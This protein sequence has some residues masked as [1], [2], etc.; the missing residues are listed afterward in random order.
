MPPTLNQLFLMVTDLDRSVR[1]YRDV[2]DLSVVEERDSQAVFDTG[3]CSLV[4]EEDFDAETLAGFNLDPPGDDRGDGAIV[5][6]EV[7]DVEAAYE[8]AADADVGETLTEPRRVDWGRELFLV[9]DPD[10]YVVEVS[11]PVSE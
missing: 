4:V 2:L 10:G 8:T 6:L 1:F 11:R 9:A 7:D 3:E 5:V